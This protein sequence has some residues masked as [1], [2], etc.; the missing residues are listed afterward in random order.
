MITILVKAN[1]CRDQVNV[2]WVESS[3]KTIPPVDRLI[4]QSWTAAMARPGIK[5]FDGP[6]SRLESWHANPCELQLHLSQTSYKIFLGTNLTHPELAAEYGREVMANPV[7]LSAAIFS[8]DGYL[9]FGRRNSSVAYYP[10]RVHPFAGCLEPRDGEDVFAAI[11]RELTEELGMSRADIDDIRC[12]GIVEDRELL[13]PELIFRVLSTRTRDEVERRVDEK[14]HVGS[15]AI[16]ATPA[17]IAAAKQD[18]ELTP[19]AVGAL[20]LC[21]AATMEFPAAAHP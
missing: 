10:N 7:G 17:A 15:W 11:E 19:V 6:M 16:E 13:Q 2:S 9:L 21:E 12:R 20:M 4:E 14:E 5:L 1:W 8:S 3:R 18:P